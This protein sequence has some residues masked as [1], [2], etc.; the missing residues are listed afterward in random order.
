MIQSDGTVL[1]GPD[2]IRNVFCSQNI[3]GSDSPSSSDKED[4]EMKTSAKSITNED[5]LWRASNQSILADVLAS[6]M[7]VN[8]LVR[9][10]FMATAVARS[11][12][13]R[14]DF[15][16]GCTDCTASFAIMIPFE[17]DGDAS[18]L[19]LATT[20]IQLTYSIDAL[21]CTILQLQ[22]NPSLDASKDLEIAAQQYAADD[23]FGILTTPEEAVDRSFLNDQQRDAFI[24]E[25]IGG[26]WKQ[27]DET[28][29]IS[30]KIG[31]VSTYF[32]TD[33]KNCL[34]DYEQEVLE[35]E[36]GAGT[37]N[38]AAGSAVQRPG[39][40]LGG[41]LGGLAKVALSA[42]QG[43]DESHH[44]PV[45]F[46]RK[47]AMGL[48]NNNKRAEPKTQNIVQEMYHDTSRQNLSTTEGWSDEELD[49]DSNFSADK[50]SIEAKQ[51]TIK[52]QN[53]IEGGDCNTNALKDENEGH[54]ERILTR[55]RWIRPHYTEYVFAH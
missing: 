51:R 26:A 28:T 52:L 20:E 45:Q 14:V 27:L 55:K 33:L 10:Q 1:E 25:G 22:T 44:E 29:G 38:V 49:F 30:N 8:G 23:S 17:K 15:A 2:A 54:D 3:N 9:P 19:E 18:M 11:V 34:E 21:S 50:I 7:D 6:M 32:T 43:A 40:L 31:A 35:E 36:M 37:V 48:P 12:S 41:M 13:F 4:T 24:V 46:Y 42:A 39:S 47:E 5:F 53:G 16:R